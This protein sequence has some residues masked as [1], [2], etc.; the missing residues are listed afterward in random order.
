MVSEI[1]EISGGL[2]CLRCVDTAQTP[3]GASVAAIEKSGALTLPKTKSSSGT[4][5]G[6]CACFCGGASSA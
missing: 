5:K 6:E 2:V 4:P 1:S 3:T